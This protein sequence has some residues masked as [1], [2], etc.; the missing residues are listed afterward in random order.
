MPIPIKN[1]F[2]AAIRK[3][4]GEILYTFSHM[5][6]SD[7]FLVAKELAEALQVMTE[8][9]QDAAARKAQDKALRASEAR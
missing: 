7:Q 1:R 6:L 3:S 9:I 8:T 2:R 4:L 5:E